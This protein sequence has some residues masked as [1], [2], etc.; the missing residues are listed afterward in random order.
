MTEFDM[1]GDPHALGI[2]P[3]RLARIATHFDAYVASGRLPGWLV[4]VSR[5]GEL[6]WSARGGMRDVSAGL[7]V[8]DDTIWRIYSMTKPI[9]Q[10]AAMILFEEG[11][12]DLNDEVGRWIEA[13][14]EPRIFVGG[15]A[16][17]PE[18]VPS[19]S[20]MRVWHLMSHTSGLTY[21]FQRATPVDEIYRLKGHDLAHLKETDLAGAV[22][23]W[24]TSPLL[25]EPGTRFNYSVSTD[26]LGRLVEIWS[27]RPFGEFVRER[28][29]EP[30]GLVDTDWWCPPDKQDRLAELYVAYDGGIFPYAD[31]AGNARREPPYCSGGGGLVSTARDYER[32]MNFL[33]QGGELDGV[34]LLSSR[35][36]DLMTLNHLPGGGDLASVALD[37]YAETDYEGIGFGLGFAVMLDQV[38]NRSL[39]T[40][41]SY[42]WGGAA[43]TTFWVDPA[44][45]LAVGFFTQL[46]PPSTYPLRREL[47]QLVYQALVD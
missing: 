1:V 42:F 11:R 27:G 6:A 43:S 44:E 9:T 35:T 10:V 2:D 41:G 31:M 16:A 17:E 13:L 32:F 19:I 28:V 21:D 12:F 30:L 8:T 34:R 14:A 33:L 25:F 47:R 15:T 46:L 37:S 4:T 38:R 23:D 22:D 18:T 29:L 5:G 36:L 24:C 26:V 45:D 39:T 20:P 40:P 7:E 3:D